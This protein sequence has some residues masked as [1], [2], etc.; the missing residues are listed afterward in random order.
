MI[1]RNPADIVQKISAPESEMIFLNID[2]VK[3]LAETVIDDPYGSEVRRAFFFGCYTGL[4]ISDIET[5][6]WEKI[7]TNPMQIIKSQEKTKN[8]AY[9]P[10]NKSAQNLIVDGKVHEAGEKVFN[11]S[12]HNRRTSYIHLKSWA[13]KSG[14]KKTIGW[15]GAAHL[16]DY[17]S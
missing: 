3:A 10:L 6:T 15:H 2:E 16:C 8:P 11:L 13:E 12:G 1:L 17:G 4:R 7:E 14:I 5:L 9:I